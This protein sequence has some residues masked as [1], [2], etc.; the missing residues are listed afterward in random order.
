MSHISMKFKLSPKLDAHINGDE[1]ELIVPVK[2]EIE[3]K[4][5]K[6]MLDSTGLN[7]VTKQVILDEVLTIIEEAQVMQHIT[8]QQIKH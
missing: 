3:A 7:N 1:L 2:G 6:E 4:P 8:E 5:L